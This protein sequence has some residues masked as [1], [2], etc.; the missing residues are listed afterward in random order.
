M[1]QRKNLGVKKVPKKINPKLIPEV[2]IG[3]VGH[4]AHGKCIA[5]KED[6]LIN[7]RLI[8]GSELVEL[9]KNEG[10]LINSRGSEWLYDIPDLYTFSLDSNLEMVKTKAQVF[11]QKYRGRVLNI[12][13]KGGRRIKVTPKHPFLVNVNGDLIWKKAKDI[14]VGDYIAVS[15]LCIP[16]TK[17]IFN[18]QYVKKLKEK[19]YLVLTHKEFVILR[20]KMRDFTDFSNASAKDFNVL[21]FLGS[22]SCGEIARSTGFSISWIEKILIGE[23]K[24]T[25]NVRKKLVKFFFD[26]RQKIFLLRK[27]EIFVGLK[28]SPK[29]V[30]FK[31]VE[32]ID[33]RLIKWFAFL[34]AEGH[35]NNKGFSV[36]Q[37]KYPKLLDEFKKITEEKFGLKCKKIRRKDGMHVARVNCAPFASYLRFKFGVKIGRSGSICPWIISLPL[38]LQVHFL[39]EFFALEGNAEKNFIKISQANKRS[40]NVLSVMLNNCGID[41]HLNFKKR[42]RKEKIEHVY[43][44]LIYGR[45][46]LKK[47]VEII[48]IH[49]RTQFKIVSEYLSKMKNTK[50]PLSYSLVPINPDYFVTI[51]KI[52]PAYN[53]HNIGYYYYLKR[54][55]SKSKLNQIVRGL[56]SWISLAEKHLISGCKLSAKDMKFFG[57]FQTELGKGMG[58]S[59][60]VI[61]DILHHRRKT[62]I[63]QPEFHEM[64]NRLA[65]RKLKDIKN[66]HKKL[67]LLVSPNVM[68][69]EIINVTPILYNDY[70]IDLVVPKFNNFVAGFGGVISHN[71]SLVEAIAGQTTLRHSEELKRGITIRLGYADATIYKCDKGHYTTSEKCPVCFS[72]ATVQRTVSFVDAPG[73]ETLMAIVLTGT[74]LMDGAILLIAADE[75]CPQPQTREH[76][77]TLEVVGIK[78]VIIVQNKIDTVSKERA[79]QSYN[80][81]KKFVEDSAL[82]DAPIIPVSSQQRIN[83]DAVIDS[84]EKFIPTPERDPTKEPRMVVARSFDINRPGTDLNKLKGGVLGGAITQGRLKLG[85]EIEIRPGVQVGNKYRPLFTSV[86][87]LQK[88]GIDLPDAG[89]GGLLGVLTMLDPALTKSD[90]LVGNVVGLPGKLPEVRDSMSLDVKL[91]ERV[92]GTE[93]LGLVAPIKPEETLMI[94]VGTAR[95]VG[96]VSDIKK[97]IVDLKLKIPVC[98]EEKE[99]VVISRQ[100]AGRWRLVGHGRIIQN[101]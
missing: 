55:V 40:I 69:D 16:P 42:F 70:V 27:D 53:L 78:N 72:T 97:G 64:F 48:G 98:A 100:V 63:I 11:L 81:I 10:K 18:S 12:L 61:Y 86:E 51:G 71:T 7:N 77:T 68:W 89:A 101:V 34:H 24:M 28:T 2:N 4:V 66:I 30:R 9:V 39:R 33:E 57:I 26:N 36:C 25:E 17:V 67:K 45:Y 58:C 15:R 94:N 38:R 74:S 46:N 79:L 19:H 65:S 92:V 93:E 59:K 84:I 73:H 90:S 37:K 14:K 1:N 21:R 23:K 32:K 62:R 44:V 80:E 8:S 56:E 35:V 60:Y 85:D 29:S 13:T 31:D 49:N 95:S 88:A 20:K 76:L 82:K 50:N 6:I 52:L 54:K 47:F 99:R 22:F 75:K 83:I 3:M 96:T 41:H 43:S 5:L 91:L 87:G